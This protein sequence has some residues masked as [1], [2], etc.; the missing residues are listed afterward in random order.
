MSTPHPP[1]F[2]VRPVSNRSRGDLAGRRT[3][4]LVEHV[5]DGDGSPFG[6]FCDPASDASS[7]WW[8]GKRG[9]REQY[10]NPD[11]DRFWAQADGNWDYHSV[12]T[13]GHPGEP[14]TD[15]QLESFAVLMAWGAGRYGWPLALA[16]HPGAPGLGYHA[17][18]GR[19]WGGHPY[20]PGTLRLAARP[21]ILARSRA[22][23]EGDDMADDATI[24]K[25]AEASAEAVWA[26]H[27]KDPR[28]P[29]YAP[30]AETWVKYAN[31]K[32]GVDVATVDPAGL[33]KAVAAALPAG[34]VTDEQ[35]ERVLRGLFG[36]LDEEAPR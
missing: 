26:H 31:I 17:M 6:W 25:I 34:P 19:S 18:G 21:T 15:P 4:G 20:C 11:T 14:L 22:I 27:L 2:T 5:Q 32:A 10:G 30:T 3:L 35:L 16:N 8:L 23:T 33:A 28:R 13:E 36:S 12:E 7:T 9:E 1:G 24:R 29:D